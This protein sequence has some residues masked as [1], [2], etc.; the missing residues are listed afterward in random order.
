MKIFKNTW[1]SF[2]FKS[3]VYFEKYWRKLFHD[4]FYSSSFQ[5]VHLLHQSIVRLSQPWRK[6][7][8]YLFLSCTSLILCQHQSWLRSHTQVLSVSYFFLSFIGRDSMRKLSTEDDDWACSLIDS[9]HVLHQFWAV[10][11]MFIDSCV[12][13]PLFNVFL[14]STNCLKSSCISFGVT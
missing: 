1:N 8:P 4:H 3:L 7:L 9:L 12:L 2:V 13:A 5:H 10:S 6:H 11:N 14:K